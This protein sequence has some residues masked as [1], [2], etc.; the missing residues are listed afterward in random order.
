[1]GRAPLRVRGDDSH[2]VV[3]HQAVPRNGSVRLDAAHVT[4]VVRLADIFDR[5]LVEAQLYEAGMVHGVELRGSA[6]TAQPAWGFARHHAGR[7]PPQLRDTATLG[8]G[9]SRAKRGSVRCVRMAA[10]VASPVGGR[11]VLNPAQER[12]TSRLQRLHAELAQYRVAL[13]VHAEEL[14]RWRQMEE[15]ARRRREAEHEVR[16]RS[17]WALL[18]RARDGTM[19]TVRARLLR[20]SEGSCGPGLSDQELKHPFWRTGLGK[21]VV[22]SGASL[23]ASADLAEAPMVELPAAP[24]PPKPPRGVYIWG[25]VGSGKTMVRQLRVTVHPAFRLTNA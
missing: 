18:K 22:E 24:L 6:F 2:L 3:V 5:F 14:R 12:L 17:P 11:I 19:A 15:E 10:R 9:T 7:S 23:P 8:P 13:A 21:R 16:R 20:S 4:G 25:P 1:M